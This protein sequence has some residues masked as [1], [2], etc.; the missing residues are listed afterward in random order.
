MAIPSPASVAVRVPAPS[1]IMNNLIAQNTRAQP[2]P[3]NAKKL[4]AMGVPSEI[5]R[6]GMSEAVET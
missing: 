6:S 4:E 2:K 3:I 5:A 1:E